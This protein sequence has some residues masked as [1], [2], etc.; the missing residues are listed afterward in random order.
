MDPASTRNFIRAQYAIHPAAQLQD[1]RKAL[2]QSTF[3]CEHLILDVSAAAAGIREEYEKTGESRRDV[4]RLDGPWSRIYLGVLAD[5]LT[6]ETL[7]AAFARSAAMPHED[8]D[9]LEARVSVLLELV[10]AG[11]LP[12]TLAETLA[13]LS[14]WR[15]T[16][17]PA[18][19]HSETYRSAYRPAYRVLH[20]SYARLL[21]LLTAIDRGLSDHAQL[22]LA[23]EG[24]AASGKST[25]AALLGGLYD[26]NILHVDDFF[27]RPEQRTAQR[28]A[29]PG[30][31][32]DRERLEAEVLQPLRRGETAVYRPFDCHTLSFKEAVTVPPKRLNI[33]EGS[34]SFHPE[35]AHYYDLSAFLC[36]TPET[37]HR[38]IL[39]RNG[40]EWGQSFFQRWIPMEEA[41]FRGADTQRRCNMILEEETL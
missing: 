33:V 20:T 17:F 11:E 32:L 15:E 34:Y 10:R 7:A 12:Y 38:R 24:G 39:A 5:G 3:G 1:M 36:V 22:L 23:I 8:A 13:E 21:P 35:L 31:N 4:E 25:L 37:Q 29:Q 14:C 9:A 41:Y 16:G 18:C 6:P 19:R 2:H 30:G 26:A 27:L 40:P 28:Y